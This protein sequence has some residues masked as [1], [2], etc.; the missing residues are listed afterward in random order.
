MRRYF[1]VFVSLLLSSVAAL[2]Q[3]RPVSD[4]RFCQFEI[5]QGLKQAHATFNV[6][7]GFEVGAEGKPTRVSPALEDKWV[8]AEKVNA[9]LISWRFTGIPAGAKGTVVFQWKHEVGW[10]RM[11]VSLPQ[12][13][14][15]VTIEGNRCPYRGCEKEGHPQ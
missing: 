10:E 4:V 8:G 14:Q 9:C 7:Y 15:S 2:G 3:A 6:V 12:V 5:P 13:M 1:A 11:S